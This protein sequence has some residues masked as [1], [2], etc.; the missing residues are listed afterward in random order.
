MKFFT[1]SFVNIDSTAFKKSILLFFLLAFVIYGK[2]IFNEY[3]MDDEYVV[4][5]NIQVHKGIKAIPEIFKTTYVIDNKK[6]SYEYRPLVKAT[7][8]IEYQFFKEN[9]HISHFINILLYVL[10]VIILYVVMLKLF[11]SYHYL[12]SLSICLVFLLHPIHSEVVLSL[13]NRDV[14]LSFIGCFYSLYFYLKYAENS[15]II[16]LFWGVF[17][18]FF[19]LI[20]KRDSMTFYA[21]IPF[22]IWYFKDVSWKKLGVIILLNALPFLFFRL[23]SNNVETR[24][25]RKLLFWENPFFVDSTYLDRIP[26]GIYSIYFY[27]KLFI[28]PHPLI[29]YYGYNQV[30]IVGWSH[31]VVLITFFLLIVLAFFFFKKI[32]SKPVWI[33]GLVY[34]LVG[35]SMFTNIVKPVVGIV[36]ERFAFIPSVGLCITLIWLVFHYFKVP[37]SKISA[38]F[39]AM[40][41]SI[42]V[43]LI[44]VAILFGGKTFSRNKAWKDSY[45]L[46]ETD[47]KTATESAHTFSL[48]AASS[49]SKIRSNPKMK[50]AEKKMHVDNAIKYYRESLRILPDYITSLNNL[51]MVYYTYYNKPEESIPY[52]EKAIALDT[53][54]SE[55]YFNYASC[56]AALKHYDIAEQYYRK[57]I[58]MYDHA[59]KMQK[60]HKIVVDYITQELQKDNVEKKKLK[61][62]LK[63]I[64]KQLADYLNYDERSIE[65]INSYY[66]LSNM[67]AFNK[68]YD[69]IITLNTS[70]IEKEL[71]SDIPYINIGNVYFMQGDTLKALP[72]LENAIAHN[73]NNRF[74]NTFLS[75]YYKKEGDEKKSAYYYNLMTKSSK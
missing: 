45:T 11:E 12:F 7:Y 50:N 58:S 31:P 42:F 68:Q 44:A 24:I 43:F 29:S 17:F 56:H 25:S 65:F 35:I 20:S 41:T 59:F 6:S 21:I 48:L 66:S 15:K 8:A 34:F 47:V 60:V 4:K 71:N 32:K 61:R 57:V 10:S 36:G 26:E 46:Y 37:I 53:N 16:N 67:F 69:K 5:D 14:I 30:P 28:F 18:M 52:L 9:P 33:F 55:A 75:D 70:A 23:A 74:L 38:K 22:T 1:T 62:A 73:W 51:G 2:S 27:I 13:K 72:Y 40:G 39:S 64:D 63:L 49:V 3:A 54:Y 19:A